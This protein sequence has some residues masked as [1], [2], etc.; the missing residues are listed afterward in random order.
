MTTTEDFAKIEQ[1]VLDH[2]DRDE[3]A[4]MVNEAKTPEQRAALKQLLHLQL[5]GVSSR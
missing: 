1:R 4:R 3:A 5:Y 2:L